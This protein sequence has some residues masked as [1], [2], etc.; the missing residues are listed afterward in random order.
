[1]DPLVQLILERIQCTMTEAKI[2]ICSTYLCRCNFMDNILLMKCIHL[3]KYDK[4]TVATNVPL[5]TVAVGVWL[6]L[7]CRKRGE[8]EY[9]EWCQV[10]MIGTAA[11]YLLISF[12][13]LCSSMLEPTH[14]HTH[15]SS[16]PGQRVTANSELVL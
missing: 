5:Y 14:T 7:S 1:M 9:R 10:G 12:C 11:A 8:A 2:K 16:L 3:H 13:C 6:Q 15:R 4:K